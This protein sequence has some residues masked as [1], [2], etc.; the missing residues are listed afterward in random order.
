MHTRIFQ[1]IK[2]ASVISLP[3]VMSDAQAQKIES[4]LGE[5]Y[6]KVNQE[7]TY[8]LGRHEFEP[9]VKASETV[10]MIPHSTIKWGDECDLSFELNTS[11][12]LQRCENALRS[13]ASSAN[14]FEIPVSF[15]LTDADLLLARWNTHFAALASTDLLPQQD[16]LRS[17]RPAHEHF[18][19]VLTSRGFELHVHKR[20]R[21]G[22]CRV[23][24]TRTTTQHPETIP[25]KV[26]SL[27]TRDPS[28]VLVANQSRLLP[29]FVILSND[30]SVRTAMSP[31]GELSFESTVENTWAKP[32]E[33]ISS[34][35]STVD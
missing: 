20:A 32:T 33:K 22:R 14:T 24:R 30:G 5:S 13:F 11:L 10:T 23:T 6:F 8:A 3:V 17:E 29:L 31:N 4:K 35:L 26:H 25:L 15:D 16:V 9:T 1:L 34:F 27:D 7:M 18:D 28:L 19:L 21:S 2:I 12:R